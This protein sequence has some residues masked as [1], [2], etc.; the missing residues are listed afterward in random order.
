V[1]VRSV[2]SGFLF[3]NCHVAW[4]GGG[5]CVVVDP[6]GEEAMILDEIRRLG[7]RPSLLVATHAHVDAV[8]AA[9]A[10]REAFA[11]PLAVHARE[12]AALA[13]LVEEAARGGLHGVR[14]AAP[15]LLLEEGDVVGSGEAAL[16]VIATPGHTPGS[17]CLEGGG[18]VFTGD[19][20]L[21]GSYGRADGEGAS[22]EA[23]VASIVGKL[24]ALPD[25]TQVLPG[26]GPATTIG[27]EKAS[28]WARARAATM[29]GT[30]GRTR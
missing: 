14:A 7:V 4:D 15:D 20:L 11:A 18:V 24:F 27:R 30:E 12:A 5:S 10:L 21:R 19:T 2:A 16:R 8:G 23:L 25:G 17:I 28:N 26:H 6:G 22:E 13:A 3:G 29:K 1:R 9:A